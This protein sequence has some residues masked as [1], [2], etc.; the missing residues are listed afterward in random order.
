MGNT[1][2]N[3]LEATLTELRLEL[4]VTANDAKREDIQ[5]LITRFEAVLAHANGVET[6]PNL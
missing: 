4:K 2:Q 6:L 1:L 3:N 5:R